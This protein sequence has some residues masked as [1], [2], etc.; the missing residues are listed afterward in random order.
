M[1]TTNI[2]TTNKRQVT[3][4][5]LQSECWKWHHNTYPQDRDC[6][7]LILA[8]PRNKIHGKQL[9]SMGFKKGTPDM[10]WWR[11]ECDIYFEFKVKPDTVKKEQ[12]ETHELLHNQGKVVF[13]IWSLYQYQT[14]VKVTY[15]DGTFGR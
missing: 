9:I 3:H 14:I 11:K 13:I 2:K 4:D 6:L 7:R 1:K 10:V 12:K 8:N 15:N 5:R